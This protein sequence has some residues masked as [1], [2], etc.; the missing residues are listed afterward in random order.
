MMNSALQ[1]INRMASIGISVRTVR[2][3]CFGLLMAGSVG[4]ATDDSATTLQAVLQARFP[5]IQIDSVR[6]APFMGLYEVLTP[7]EIVYSDAKGELLFVGKVIDAKSREDLT[8]KRWLETQRIDFASLPLDQAIKFVKGTG[9][10]KLAVFADPQC[11]H[12]ERFERVLENTKDITVYLFLLPIKEI[13]PNAEAVARNIWCS[14]DQAAA[15]T[16]WMLK[17][18]PPPAATCANDPLTDI[19]ALG[20][21]LKVDGTPTIFFADGNRAP[22]GLNAEQLES[23]LAERVAA[24]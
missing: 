23:A 12:C 15:W 6:A 16:N 13:H 17:K 8:A 10:R 21:K 18:M 1:A 19:A 11:P 22:G 20:D 14:D 2:T 7:S 24:H 9:S 3:L 4:A 5:Q